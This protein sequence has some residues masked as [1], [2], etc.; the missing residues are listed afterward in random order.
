MER[1]TITIGK[2]PDNTIQI[3]KPDISGHHARITQTGV[4][5]FF[6]EDL[7]STNHTF[8]DG[9]PI[10]KVT[11][12]LEEQLRLS[13][14]TIIDLK[15]AF[16]ISETSCPTESNTIYIDS[17]YRLKLL[18]EETERQKKL[19]RKRQQR[20]SA[21]IRTGIMLGIIACVWPFRAII[22]T[23]FFIIS[24]A[25]GGIAGAFVPVAA[26]EE[27]RTLDERLH[28]N[29]VCPHCE[30]KLG[31]WSWSYY[32]ENGKCHSCKKSFKK[33]G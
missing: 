33:D 10:R 25:A 3:R 28:R 16:Q 5:S 32:A 26:P 22:G 6:V 1:K 18:W 31:Q 23:E 9:V 29:Y 13:R 15:S 20:K 17:F 2:E 27:L 24:I 7:D 30:A 12:G 4:N 11:I 8:V 19:I 21:F 14:D